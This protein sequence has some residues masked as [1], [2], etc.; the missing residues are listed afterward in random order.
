MVIV[1]MRPLELLFA[2]T[3]YATDPAPLPLEPAVMLIHESLLTADQSQPAGPLTVTMSEPPADV[4]DWF[5]GLMESGQAEVPSCA[6]ACRSPAMMMLTDRAGP[7]FAATVYVILA[8]PDPVAEEFSVTQFATGEL[9]HEHPVSASMRTDMEPPAAG[10][11]ALEG[12]RDR[13][14]VLP[15]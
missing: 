1:P 9:L 3:E 14:Q 5:D 15:A 4:N 10:N 11:D 6:I 2:P 13:A 8:V 12:V 7:E